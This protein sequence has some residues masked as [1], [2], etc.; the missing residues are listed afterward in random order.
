M[1]PPSFYHFA[2]LVPGLQWYRGGRTGLQ[3]KKLRVYGRSASH[4]LAP[5]KGLPRP[6]CEPGKVPVPAKQSYSQVCCSGIPFF[7]CTRIRG[8]GVTE[9]LWTEIRYVKLCS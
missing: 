1:V 3:G 7:D 9:W 8:I 5:R 2:P 4:L 6:F